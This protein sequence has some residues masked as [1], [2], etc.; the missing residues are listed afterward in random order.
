MRSTSTASRLQG[1][2]AGDA[3]SRSSHRADTL[4]HLLAC[5]AGER[6]QLPGADDRDVPLVG[7]RRHEPPLLSRYASAKRET[8]NPSGF[9]PQPDVVQDRPAGDRDNTG[10]PGL[11]GERLVERREPASAVPLGRGR[12]VFDGELAAAR[13]PW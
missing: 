5:G 7:E 8:F 3:S 4:E 9:G 12:V 6:A 2:E 1:E 10:H 13:P 11:T